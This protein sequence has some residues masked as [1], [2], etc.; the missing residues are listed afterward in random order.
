MD[1]VAQL[2]QRLGHATSNAVIN[3]INSKVM[4]CHVSATNVRNTD[5]AKNVS[6]SGLL[7]KTTK[8]TSMPPGYMLVPRVRQIQQILGIDIMFIKQVTFL[9]GLFPP[10]GLGFVHVLRNCSE[11]Q[12][13]TALRFMFT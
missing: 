2:A 4:N 1:K 5:A 6:I 9:L 12:V 8:K 7:G 11:A 13:G 3:I 10:L